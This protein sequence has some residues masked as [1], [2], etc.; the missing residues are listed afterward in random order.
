MYYRPI[1]AKVMNLD[2][3]SDIVGEKK[4]SNKKTI[5]KKNPQLASNC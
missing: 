1:V 3:V 5:K 4:T 2:H